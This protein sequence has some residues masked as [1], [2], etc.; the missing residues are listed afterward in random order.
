ML[1]NK[2][3]NYTAGPCR[4]L[5][6]W[7]WSLIWKKNY[8]LV[9]VLC[10]SF[11]AWSLTLSPSNTPLLSRTC[12]SHGRG[13]IVFF[14]AF[15]NLPNG[16]MRTDLWEAL[17][18]LRHLNFKNQQLFSLRL[19]TIDYSLIKQEG[20]RSSKWGEHNGKFVATMILSIILKFMVRKSYF[21]WKTF[22]L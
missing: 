7:I 10:N 14:S 2:W 1:I 9:T 17:S 6:I 19:I 3:V 13:K 20:L 18:P 12:A 11:H 5:K 22:H 8:F 16:I 15:L 21:E 4:L